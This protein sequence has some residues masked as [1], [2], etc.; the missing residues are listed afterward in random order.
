[1][2]TMVAKTR[3]WARQIGQACLIGW[4]CSA[5]PACLCAHLILLLVLPP[6]VSPY[7]G[8]VLL[9][10]GHQLK[11]IAKQSKLLAAASSCAQLLPPALDSAIQGSSHA[12]RSP[13]RRDPTLRQRSLDV[14]SRRRALNVS[15]C[16]LNISPPEHAQSADFQ[17]VC[18]SLLIVS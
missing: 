12:T 10:S 16:A 3:L 1:M 17:D 18:I 15:A 8:V 11:N 6:A 13:E 5:S 9:L 7:S 4:V 2:W 14:S